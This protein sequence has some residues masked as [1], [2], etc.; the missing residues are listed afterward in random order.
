MTLP[1]AK[2]GEYHDLPRKWANAMDLLE[3]T[4]MG[5]LL[6]ILAVI[7]VHCGNPGICDGSSLDSRIP[8][9]A[10]HF[11]GVRVAGGGDDGNHR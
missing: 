6:D 2:M 3:F 11:R 4:E 8:A 5:D 9:L 10:P 7:P 1:T